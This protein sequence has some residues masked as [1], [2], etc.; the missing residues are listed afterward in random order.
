MAC[1]IEGGLTRY[2]V[3]ATI[4][5]CMTENFLFDDVS[6]EILP[7]R[8]AIFEFAV[9]QPSTPRPGLPSLLFGTRRPRLPGHNFQGLQDTYTI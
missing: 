6:S 8:T 5:R 4:M 9:S 7:N 1:W 3:F 2:E